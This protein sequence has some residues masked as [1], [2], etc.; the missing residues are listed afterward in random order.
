MSEYELNDI[1]NLSENRDAKNKEV[2]TKVQ[3]V[4]GSSETN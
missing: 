4:G 3:G 1:N 2:I